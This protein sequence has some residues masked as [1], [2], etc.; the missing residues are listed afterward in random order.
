MPALMPAP[1]LPII[2]AEATV[3]MLNPAKITSVLM[4]IANS[5]VIDDVDMVRD[6]R[7]F[8]VTEV[9]PKG[10]FDVQYDR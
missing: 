9:L 7:Y 1:M 3:A 8:C 2:P 5:F 6:E 4:F 10:Y